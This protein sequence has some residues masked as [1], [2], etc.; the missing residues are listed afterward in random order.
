MRIETGDGRLFTLT[1]ERYEFPDEELGPTE[2]NPAED[3]DT[4][5]FLIVA[6]SFQNGDGKWDARGPTMTTVELN[7]FVEWLDS[8]R[9]GTR[10]TE[11]FYFTE[12]DLEFTFDDSNQ[13]LCV[14][15]FR[16]FLPT[17]SKSKSVTI[18][19]PLREIDMD[20]VLGSLRTQLAVFPGRPPPIEKREIT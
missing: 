2:D 7:R 17:W 3:F 13:S 19:F 12:R 15:V 10:S 8:I 11:G 9:N 18:E 5:R 14:H 6:Y 16:D 1:V 4:G 20:S